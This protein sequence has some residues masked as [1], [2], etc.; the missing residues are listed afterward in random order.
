MRGRSA[1]RSRVA[2]GLGV[3]VVAVAVLALHPG[4]RAGAKAAFVLDEAFDGPLPRPW[5][6]SIEQSE[7]KIGGVIVDRYSSRVDAPRILLL[8]GAARAGRDDARVV[9][10]ASSLAAA[11]REVVVRRLDPGPPGSGGCLPRP[12]EGVSSVEE[13]QEAGTSS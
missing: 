2:V 12:D 10:L 1:F 3:A 6:L 7:E 13:L 5:A 11:G 9:S 4:V 8:P